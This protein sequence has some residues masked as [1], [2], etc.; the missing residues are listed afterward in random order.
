MMTPL[1]D[2]ILAMGTL[3]VGVATAIGFVLASKGRTEDAYPLLIGATLTT[4]VVSAA[5]MLG[6]EGEHRGLSGLSR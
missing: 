1:E 5:R 4:A 3:A 6:A 2:K